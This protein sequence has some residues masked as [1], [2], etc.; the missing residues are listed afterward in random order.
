[1][2]EIKLIFKF[3]NLDK[4]KFLIIS[5]LLFT[6]AILEATLVYLIKPI[7]DFFSSSQH[8]FS[9]SYFLVLLFVI[10]LKFFFAIISYTLLI[11]ALYINNSKIRVLC[12]DSFFDINPNSSKF[13]YLSESAKSTLIINETNKVTS[14]L[15]SFIQCAQGALPVIFILIIFFYTNYIVTVACLST[16]LIY[17]ILFYYFIKKKIHK[18]SEKKF[19]AEQSSNVE[20]INLFSNF[21]YFKI[22]KKIHNFYQ[23]TLNKNLQNK[24]S[25]YTKHAFLRKA[26]LV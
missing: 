2:N 18:L 14:S 15:Q 20:I 11:R 23:N 4:K 19:I 7:I 21:I 17:F 22:N 8:N 24:V 3:L 25:I 16:A 1:M 12:K 6:A 13:G 5:I 9:N 26:C 10:I